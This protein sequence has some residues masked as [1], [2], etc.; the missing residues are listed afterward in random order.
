MEYSSLLLFVIK[1]QIPALSTVA[2]V[3]R[4]VARVSSVCFLWT[5][6]CGQGRGITGDGP[7]LC[8][9]GVH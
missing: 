1:R 5:G 9:Y 6:L 7:V 2:W 3:R 8:L 4:D